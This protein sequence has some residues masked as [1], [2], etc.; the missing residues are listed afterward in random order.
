M[1]WDIYPLEKMFFSSYNI[2]CFILIVLL[3][4]KPYGDSC[5][6]ANVLYPNF[7]STELFLSKE[8]KE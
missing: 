4:K 6:I 5:E 3:Q 8:N 2:S 7:L 1:N